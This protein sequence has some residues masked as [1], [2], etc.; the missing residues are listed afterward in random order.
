MSTIVAL[1]D[2]GKVPWSDLEGEADG[3]GT[4]SPKVAY[5]VVN[6]VPLRSV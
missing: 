6:L 5:S 4:R 3:D 1:M 2:A